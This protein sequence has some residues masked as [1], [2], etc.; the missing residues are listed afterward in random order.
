MLSSSSVCS[1]RLPLFLLPS[2]IA[3]ST[4]F[5]AST[6]AVEFPA[7]AVN[8]VIGAF[9]RTTPEGAL[10]ARELEGLSGS[11]GQS[12]RTQVAQRLESIERSLLSF[13]QLR[14]HGAVDERVPLA[15]AEASEALSGELTAAERLFLR[16]MA[17]RELRMNPRWSRRMTGDAGEEFE[18]L[19]RRRE[20]VSLL[21]QASDAWRDIGTLDANGRLEEPGAGA[22]PVR[23]NY[24]R[25]AA[26][27][28]RLHDGPLAVEGA[29]DATGGVGG[30]FRRM[31]SCL[32]NRSA[33]QV[34]AQR[35]SYS[36]RRLVTN[37]SM[38]L[39]GAIVGTGIQHIKPINLTFD[40][41]MS[42][43]FT[44]WGSRVQSAQESLRVRWLRMMG[45]RSTRTAVVGTLYYV[46][47]LRDTGG[48]SAGTAT[49]NRVGYNVAWDLSTSPM[50]I[51]MHDLQ[52][53]IECLYPNPLFRLGRFRESDVMD[54]IYSGA[55][56]V[57]YYRAR[58]LTIQ[59]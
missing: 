24:D 50:S 2:L 8:P 54:W 36:V 32:N 1:R 10:I 53:G 43:G 23:G 45:V 37:M 7:E 38:T 48:L 46:T 13:R 52:A 21:D 18:F 47:P 35:R 51:G 22:E 27:L 14:T 42:F 34:T 17:A 30:F 57:L 6:Y 33:T 41:L 28:S 12:I 16:E 3:A 9:L 15:E 40:L 31:R 49:V 56:S 20:T 5:S 39:G 29:G 44:L 26:E 58:W 55:T 11:A 4:L 25:D 19:S 59:Q